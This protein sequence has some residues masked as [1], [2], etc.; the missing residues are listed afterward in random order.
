MKRDRAFR[1]IRFSFYKYREAAILEILRPRHCESGRTVCLEVNSVGKGTFLIKVVLDRRVDGLQFMQISH[2]SETVH[3]AL[4]WFDRQVRIV[5]SAASLPSL[6][7]SDLLQICAVG[8]KPLRRKNFGVIG[9]R[10]CFPKVFP[11]RIPISCRREN[12][13]VHRPLVI[14]RRPRLVPLAIDRH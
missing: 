7:R 10:H 13:F 14:D 1:L 9:L 3:S 12:N 8:S 4:P 5:G 11:N 6:R 2:L